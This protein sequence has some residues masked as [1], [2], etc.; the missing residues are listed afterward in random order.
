MVKWEFVDREVVG[1]DVT[2]TDGWLNGIVL[3]FLK[4]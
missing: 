2:G 3:G 4:K 1:S